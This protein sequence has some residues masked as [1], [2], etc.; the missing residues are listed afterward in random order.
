MTTRE[1]IALFSAVDGYFGVAAGGGHLAAAFNLPTLLTVDHTTGIPNNFRIGER[2][3]MWVYP[4]QQAVMHEVEYQETAPTVFLA[5][6][7]SGH[8]AIVNWYCKQQQA[9]TWFHNE[10]LRGNPKRPN[11]TKRYDHGTEKIHR[12]YNCEDF[13]FRNL[14]LIQRKVPDARLILV[15][16]DLRNWV[17]SCLAKREWAQT[18]PNTFIYTDLHERIRIWEEHA[19]IAIHPPEWLYVISYDRWFADRGYRQ[20]I[21]EDLGFELTDAGLNDVPERGEGSSFDGVKFDGKAQEMDVLNRYKTFED[22]PEYQ[23]L[24]TPER[25]KLNERM[26]EQLKIKQTK[27]N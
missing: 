1:Y 8:H 12:V 17:A 25:L 20:Q 16:R 2:M 13:H 3:Q 27:G 6:M 21:A 10:G 14:P 23:A 7:R 24:V 18:H 9:T 11:E 4:Y 26:I 19:R 22:D 15:V 5:A